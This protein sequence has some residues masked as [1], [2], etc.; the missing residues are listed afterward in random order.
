[1]KKYYKVQTNFGPVHVVANS[2][3]S[4]EEYLY[5]KMDDEVVAYFLEYLH[6]TLEKIE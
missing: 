4:G 6:F 2:F 1:M 5:F 3:V